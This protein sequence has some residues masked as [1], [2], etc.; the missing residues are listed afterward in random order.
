MMV[1]VLVLVV[2][3]VVVV[4][5]V[6]NFGQGHRDNAGDRNAGQNKYKNNDGNADSDGDQ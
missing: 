6:G 1:L 3:L 4:V 5:L 2:V